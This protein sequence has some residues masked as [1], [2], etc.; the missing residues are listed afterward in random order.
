[1]V[2]LR[3]NPSP[4]A[5]LFF[6][7]TRI[8]RVVKKLEP[9]PHVDEGED[10]VEGGHHHVGEGEIQEEVICYTPHTAMGWKL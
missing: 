9:V 6:S 7:L 4:Q 10:G 5:C 8:L 1:M 3:F 2:E